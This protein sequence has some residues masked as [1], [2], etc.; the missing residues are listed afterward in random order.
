MSENQLA[1]GSSGVSLRTFNDLKEFAVMVSES[2][3]AVKGDTPAAIAIKIQMGLELGLT[4]MT[5]VQNIAVIN[6]RP[7]A[8]GD[9]PLGIVRATRELE[10]FDEYFYVAGKKTVTNPTEYPDT[11]M[12]VCEVTRRGMSMTRRT[13]SVADAKRAGLWGKAGPWQQYPQRMLK[14]RA[15]GFALRDA[16]G[17]ALKGLWQAEEASDIPVE[18]DVTPAKL[19]PNPYKMETVVEIDPPAETIPTVHATDASSAPAEGVSNPVDSASK[20]TSEK[21]NLIYEIGEVLNECGIDASNPGA[22]SVFEDK[23][24]ALKYLG[25]SEKLESASVEKLTKILE[26]ASVIIDA[27]VTK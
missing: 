24:R 9:V 6:G 17:D 19:P 20:E 23:C 12:A 5:A 1:L 11:V 7:S 8:W 10:A 25:K 22:L 2:G 16:F 27:E 14:L 4:P 3:L 21:S 13:F 18:R 15:R 26:H